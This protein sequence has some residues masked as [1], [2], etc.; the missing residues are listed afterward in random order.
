[1]VSQAKMVRAMSK[2]HPAG[3]EE[4]MAVANRALA[5]FAADS[6]LEWRP[7]R[8][9]YVVWKQFRPPFETAR[10]WQSF[11]GAACYPIWKRQWPH[12]GTA[13]QALYQLIRWCQHKPVLPLSQWRWWTSE[14]VRLADDRGP[15]LVQ[16]LTAGGWP[17]V[18]HCVL[19]GQPVVNGID[20]WDLEGVS[21][22]CCHYTSGCR[23]RG[24]N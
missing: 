14:R 17:E 7:G 19:C 4:R 1:M 20:W 23:Q 13:C 3:F 21:G 2:S 9:M 11:S 18:V 6:R 15:Q 8:G 5:L 12:G 24:G 16:V 10:R 22:P